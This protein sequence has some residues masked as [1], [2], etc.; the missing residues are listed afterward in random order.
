VTSKP[1]G[2]ELCN[3]FESLMFDCLKHYR[4]VN[5]CLPTRLFF[6][7]FS[8]IHVLSSTFSSFMDRRK[9]CGRR[10]LGVVRPIRQA[11]DHQSK[12]ED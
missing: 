5:G 2:T 10:S 9:Y 1:E 3:E 6:Y 7:R 11:P 8:D 4:A 12:V